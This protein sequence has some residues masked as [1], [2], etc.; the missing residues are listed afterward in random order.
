VLAVIV[1][2]PPSEIDV[3]LTV[4]DALASLACASVPLAILDAFIP[5]IDDPLPEKKLAL[6]KLTP[7]ICDP[8]PDIVICPFAAKVN[9]VNEVLTDVMFGCAAVVTV[10]AVVALVAAPDRA[11]V[12]VVADTLP[13]LMFPV[14]ARLVNVPTDVIFGCAAVVTVP[15]VVA[16]VA[17]P[18]SAPVNVVALT[19]PADMLPVTASDVNVPTDVILGC[20]AVVTVPAVVA[21]PLNA[22]VNVVALTLPALILPVTAS[23][24]SVPTLVKLEVTTVDF[25][26]VPDKFAALAVIT[27]LAAA[28]S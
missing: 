26:V 4:N 21:A 14:T 9:P 12:N 10:P 13:A 11:P 17:A 15:A 22:P 2:E 16:L 3:P 24:P 25:N 8:A 7:E 1:P 27:T 23:D 19:L 20:A 5:V 28:V 18:L 6:T